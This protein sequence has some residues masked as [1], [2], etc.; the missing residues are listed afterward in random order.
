MDYCD[1]GQQQSL[2]GQYRFANKIPVNEKRRNNE[3]GEKTTPYLH[4]QVNIYFFN[5]Y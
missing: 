1:K 2:R 3:I 5:K 4:G